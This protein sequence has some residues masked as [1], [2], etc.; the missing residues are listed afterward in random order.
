MTPRRRA[1][2]RRVG[3]AFLGLPSRLDFRVAVGIAAFAGWA[4]RSMVAVGFPHPHVV[5]WAHTNAV[6]YPA[7]DGWTATFER[8]FLTP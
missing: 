8:E 6:H 5:A 1:L 3:R 4:G 2:E 7:A